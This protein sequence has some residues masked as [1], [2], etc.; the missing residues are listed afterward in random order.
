ML[1]ELEGPFDAGKKKALE[2]YLLVQ[3]GQCEEAE[4]LFEQAVSE[5]GSGCVPSSY[6]EA[7]NL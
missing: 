3:Q 7:C 2:G 6:K 1:Q 4:K 5:G